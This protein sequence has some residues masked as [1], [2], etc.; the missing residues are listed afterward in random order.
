MRCTKCG[1][2]AVASLRAYRISLCSDCFIEFYNRMVS[3]SI[4]K[5]NI[6]KNN[7]KILAAVSGGKDSTAMASVLSDLGYDFEML[8]IDLGIGN[9]SRDSRE[10]VEKLSEILGVKLNVVSLSEH[11]IEITKLR[12]R[13]C[14][15]CGTAKR[16]I[17]NRFAREKGFTVVATGHTAEDIASFYLKNISGGQKDYA[18]KLLP[19]IDPFDEKLV[20]K[21]K[22]LF[23][24]SEK[25][26]MLY[27]ILKKLPFKSEECPFSPRQEWKEIV[28]EI[29]L[30]KPGFVKNFVRGLISEP[31]KMEFR[32]CSLCGE[33]SLGEICAFCK[34]KMKFSAL[35][36]RNDS[37][38]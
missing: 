7:D 38:N 14:S 9:Y 19:R 13:I 32:H 31:E 22:P 11:G 33:V 10:K 27:T 20:A 17:M 4:K 28:Y 34:L 25:E 26:N 35:S 1:K 37:K 23:E 16:Y 8:Y 36:T 3:R 21:A 5:Y 12:G 30:K 15:A 29:E 24:V 18:E 2:K 6:F